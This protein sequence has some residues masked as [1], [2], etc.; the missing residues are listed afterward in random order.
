MLDGVQT[1]GC[2][3]NGQT[4]RE[5]TIWLTLGSRDSIF[6][7]TPTSV[8]FCL[9]LLPPYTGLCPCQ[10]LKVQRSLG[11]VYALLKQTVNIKQNVNKVILWTS[12]YFNYLSRTTGLYRRF[13]NKTKNATVICLK[14]FTYLILIPCV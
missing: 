3:A 14:L 10:A 4:H 12:V 6:F 9:L 8:R 11:A 13:K 2:V 7:K 1:A 5:Q